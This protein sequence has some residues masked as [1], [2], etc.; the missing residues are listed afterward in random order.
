[1]RLQIIPAVLA[2]RIHAGILPDIGSTAAMMRS[3][4]FPLLMPSVVATR[5]PVN[6]DVTPQATLGIVRELGLREI[7]NREV[8]GAS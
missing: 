5:L 1:M 2:E 6:I 4:T 3:F 8:S 7:A